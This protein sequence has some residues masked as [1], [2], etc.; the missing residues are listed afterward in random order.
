MA[1]I[2]N[3]DAL[4]IGGG[5][6]EMK[7]FPKEQ[8]EKEINASVGKDVLSYGFDVIYST[9]FVGKGIIGAAIFARKMLLKS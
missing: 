2:F 8:F 1:T 9:P 3:P 7:D 5:I 4:I 6:P